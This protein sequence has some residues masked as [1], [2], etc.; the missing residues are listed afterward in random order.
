M[1]M[2]AL[3]ATY[4]AYCWEQQSSIAFAFVISL[5]LS[6]SDAVA[7]VLRCFKVFEHLLISTRSARQ[8]KIQPQPGRHLVFHASILLIEILGFTMFHQFLGPLLP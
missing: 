8:S 4:M 3:K 7:V 6:L 1:G 5:A 2:R